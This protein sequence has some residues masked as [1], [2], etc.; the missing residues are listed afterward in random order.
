MTPA[1]EKKILE[2]LTFAKTHN[3]AEMTWQQNGLRVAFRRSM[4]G[5][6]PVKSSS[7]H[8]AAPVA[9]EAEPKK[10][11]IVR[12]PMVGRFRRSLS[13]DRPPLVVEGTRV[14]PGERLGVVDCMKIPT[15]VVCLCEGKITKILI[16][17]GQVVE[18]GQPLFAVD[19][20]ETVSSNWKN[21]AA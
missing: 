17:D 8:A 15:D 7:A 4:N 19:A 2:L 5:H 12:C 3:L 11:E 20:S 21:G 18:Y 9:V 1:A 13:K 6:S 14:K 10:E 16:E